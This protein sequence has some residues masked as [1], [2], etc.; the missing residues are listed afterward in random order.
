MYCK[1]KLTNKKYVSV[2]AF[3]IKKPITINFL[4]RHNFLLDDKTYELKKICFGTY[5]DLEVLVKGNV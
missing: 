3:N 1:I 5:F 4:T 2:M